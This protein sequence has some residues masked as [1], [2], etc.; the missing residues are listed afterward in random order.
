MK[1]IIKFDFQNG[2]GDTFLSLFDILNC[3]D[4]IKKNHPELYVIFL[5]NDLYNINTLKLVLNTE[6]FE[7][8]VDEFNI[9]NIN[10]LFINKNGFGEYKGTKFERIYSGRNDFIK[11][12]IPGIYDVYSEEKS[13]EYVSNLKI[14]FLDFTFDNLDER[15]KYF[16][17]FNESLVER[18]N[19]FIQENLDY[20]FESIYYRAINPLNYNNLNNFIN[21][22]KSQIDFSKKY[23]MCSNSALIKKMVKEIGVD[24]K[25]FRDLDSHDI[26]HIPNGFVRFGQLAEDAIFPV[27]EMIILG[28][29][30]N[31][32]YSGDIQ[33]VSLF[34]WYAINVKK[35][36]L[37]NII[38]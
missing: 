16:P 31:I 22:L 9:L 8:I 11:N 33:H 2:W 32:I 1:I 27:T 10:E 26:N 28:Q 17:I 3:I 30:S 35:V 23:F 13:L 14:P 37:T 29:S 4:Y 21:K 5:I 25:F 6:Y 20:K 38:L 12:N 36:N 34:N 7:G 19:K 18:A 15:V 24:V